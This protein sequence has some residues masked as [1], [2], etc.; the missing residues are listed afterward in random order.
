MA[1]FSVLLPVYDG[2]SVEF[3]ERSFASVTVDQTR[4]P[5]EVVVVRDG[6]VRQA[7]Q[8]TLERLRDE[9]E[10]PVVLVELVENRG[11]A[12]ALEAGLA[13]C[14][15]EIVARQD[16][17]DISVPRRFELQVPC[18]EG[19]ADI[20]GSAIQEFA[21]EGEP[22]LVRVVPESAEEIARYARFRSP[23]NHP[24]VVYR[25]SA[26]AAAGGYEDLRLMEDYWLFARMIHAGAMAKN[27]PEPLVNYRVGAGAY[28]RRGGMR[29]FRSEIALQK[30]MRAAG[31]TTRWTFVRNVVVRGVYRFVPESARRT[32]Y[33][34]VVRH[35]AAAPGSAREEQG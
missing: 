28:A 13:Q 11:L 9:C 1:S 6:P 30:R 17:D 2:D 3:L 19:G 33:R 26:V 27:L 22:G 31:M 15:H 21:V 25:R 35:D 8:R 20:V 29:L 16:A 34:A 32:V 4:A 5:D 24:S 14:S 12:L 23:F 10:T 7:L 18:V